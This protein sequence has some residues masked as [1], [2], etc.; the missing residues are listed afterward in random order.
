MEALKI[1]KARKGINR[2]GVRKYSKIKSLTDP[3]KEYDVA[4]IRVKNKKYYK[5]ICNCPDF[6]NRQRPCKHI[7]KFKE[8]ECLK[9]D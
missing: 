3:N 5:Y 1:Q 7:K 8:E 9:K 4:K 2:F 6:F